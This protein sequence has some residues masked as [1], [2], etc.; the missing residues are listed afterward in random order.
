MKIH[1]RRAFRAAFLILLA[2]ALAACAGNGKRNPEP[3]GSAPAGGESVA[4][5]PEDAVRVRAVARW[6]TLIDRQFDK[7]YDYLS[8]GYREVRPR[9]DYAKIMGGR[10]LQWTNARFVSATCETE[11][12]AVSIEVH[13]NFEMPV[14][15]VGTVETLTVVQENW[16]L[17]D[18][19]WYLVPAAD[20]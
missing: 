20:R 18:G 16:I 11:T 8:P 1:K 10:P 9:E 7:A 15:R 17:S 12:C 13:A 4:V 19:E 2:G 5:K 14:M 6:E 3:A